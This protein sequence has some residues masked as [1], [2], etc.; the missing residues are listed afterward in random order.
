MNFH[1]ISM[2]NDL[3]MHTH[4]KPYFLCIRVQLSPIQNSIFKSQ[5]IWVDIALIRFKNECEQFSLLERNIISIYFNLL[6]NQSIL[7]WPSCKFHARSHFDYT[8]IQVNLSGNKIFVR[9]ER[10]LWNHRRC[11][12]SACQGMFLTNQCFYIL[13]LVPYF[14]VILSIVITLLLNIK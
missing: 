9:L 12:F 13:W 8:V 4:C 11:V 3:E 2:C 5:I 6:V 14:L 7:A 1:N 10:T